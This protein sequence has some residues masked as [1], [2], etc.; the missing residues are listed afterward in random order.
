MM[1]IKDGKTEKADKACNNV[2][3]QIKSEARYY[4]LDHTKTGTPQAK[5]L[6]IFQESN[7]N[8]DRKQSPG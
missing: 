4:A 6:L 2:I 7:S 8:E 3:S 5:L 1:S